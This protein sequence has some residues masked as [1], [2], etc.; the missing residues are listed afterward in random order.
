M[1]SLIEFGISQILA[2]LA[3]VAIVATTLAVFAVR[4]R[5][6]KRT[7]KR[8]VIQDWRDV[9]ES[10]NAKL[11]VLEEGLASCKKEH[12]ECERKINGMTAFNLRL[13]A[14]E[15]RYQRKINRLERALNLEETDFGDGIDGEEDSGFG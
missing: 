10:Q 5:E 12:K 2:A 11:S 15:Q 13:Q 3:L 1:L 9:V 8:D 6:G 4:F 14:R 7:S